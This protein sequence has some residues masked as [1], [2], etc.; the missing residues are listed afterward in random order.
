MQPRSVLG[1]DENQD[2]KAARD[3]RDQNRDGQ[4]ASLLTLETKVPK[5]KLKSLRYF[6]GLPL[7]AE[8][9]RTAFHNT[10]SLE[11]VPAR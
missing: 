1:S 9:V 4:L 10:Q 2:R 8:H 3:E 5:E 11:P 6:G 7:S